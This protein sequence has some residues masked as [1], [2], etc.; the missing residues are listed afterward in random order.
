[1][2]THVRKK[3]RA[4]TIIKKLVEDLGIGDQVG[5][6]PNLDGLDEDDLKKF[7]VVATRFPMQLGAVLFG[8]IPNR[9]NTIDS[10]KVYA[11]LSIKRTGLRLSSKINEALAVEKTM[12]E[13]YET[14]P[15]WGRW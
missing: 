4:M 1:M 2:G 7:V 15:K 5:G 10:L 12:E 14:L 8:E 13:L 9:G 11:Q 3:M 6:A